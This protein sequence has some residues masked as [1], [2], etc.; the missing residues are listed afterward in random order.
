MSVESASVLDRRML[1]AIRPVDPIGRPIAQGVNVKAEGAQFLRKSNGTLILQSWAELKE[2]DSAFWKQPDSPAVGSKTLVVELTP[3]N[4]NLMPRKLALALPRDGDPSNSDDP[5]SLFQ[6]VRVTLPAKASLQPPGQ[7]CALI[8]KA[9]R[10]G[11]NFPVSGAVFRVTPESDTDRAT[12]GI[13]NCHGEALLLVTGL[14]LARVDGGGQLSP[15][16]NAT[17]ELFVDPE[18][19]RTD[20]QDAGLI[21]PDTIIAA[22]PPATTEPVIL[23]AR[24][25]TRAGLRWS[26]P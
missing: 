22:G 4:A 23:R 3:S 21:N 19:V 15:D 6:P 8:A 5:K 16:H 2:F 10:D 25:T 20:G 13:T 17:L 24:S 1:A 26:A 7:A 14:P 11:D 9:V 18:V 12:I